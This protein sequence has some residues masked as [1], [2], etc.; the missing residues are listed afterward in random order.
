MKTEIRDTTFLYPIIIIYSRKITSG[1]TDLFFGISYQILWEGN[2]F[3]TYSYMLV[4]YFSKERVSKL[5]LSLDFFFVEVLFLGDFRK[6]DLKLPFLGNL[7]IHDGGT[8]IV[9]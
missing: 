7:T 1:I 2:I 9:L 8:I 4:L 6:L 5:T 3:W